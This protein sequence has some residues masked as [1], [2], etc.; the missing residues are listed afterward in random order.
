ME[1]QDTSRLD[2]CGLTSYLKDALT[3]MLESRPTDPMHFLTEYFHMVA[4]GASPSHRAYRYLRLCPQDRNMF[5]DNLAAAYTLLDA[6]GGSV[7]MTGKEYMMLLRQLCADFPEVIVQILFQVLGKSETETVTFQDFSGGIRA[8]MTY[9]EFLEEA[10]NL[11]YDHTDGSSGTLSKQVLK[12][13]IARL[14]RKSL[15][16]DEER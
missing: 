13:L 15:P 9:E 11:F 2:E 16:V 12:K 3:I 6:E 10:E 4:N 14:A 5:M 7:G 1:N 8:C